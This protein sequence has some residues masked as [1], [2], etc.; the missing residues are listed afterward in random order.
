MN[1]TTV[2]NR[3][4]KPN[5]NE[6][7]KV[8]PKVSNYKLIVLNTNT[9]LKNFVKSTGGALKLILLQEDIN[10]RLKKVV[11][12][13]QKDDAMYKQLD[14]KVRRNK[15]GLTSPFY[16]LQAIYKGME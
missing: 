9:S 7:I 15:K 8:A 11:K 6:A 1:S 3:V 4:R 5:T 16:V 12:A 14:S 10:P 13:I 2:K